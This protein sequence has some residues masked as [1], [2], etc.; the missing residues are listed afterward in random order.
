MGAAFSQREASGA[1]HPGGSS[2]LWPAAVPV[3]PTDPNL[4]VA[5]SCDRACHPVGV[6]AIDG[7]FVTGWDDPMTGTQGPGTR[8]ALAWRGPGGYVPKE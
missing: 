1:A 2:A 3:S 5:K 7:D 6:T 4:C 8:P